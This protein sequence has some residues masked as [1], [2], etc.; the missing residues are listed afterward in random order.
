MEEGL[1]RLL[2][3]QNLTISLLEFL[4]GSVIVR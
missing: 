4:P 1:D 3:R 2:G